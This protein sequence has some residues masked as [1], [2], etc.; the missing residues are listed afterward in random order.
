MSPKDSVVYPRMMKKPPF[1]VEVP[2]VEPV[3]GETIPRRHPA[4]RDG[5][6]T[7]PADDLT[8]IYD[9]FRRSARVYGNAKAVGS[10]RLIKTHVETKKVKKIVDG[11]EQEVDKQWTYFEK[12]AYSYKSFVEYEKQALELGSGLRK[13]GLTK[14]DKLHLYGSTRCVLTLRMS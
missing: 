12:S 13:L 2:G 14:V 7:R 4:A 1:T 3:P 10:R 8:T 5:L 9:A 11:V 6:I